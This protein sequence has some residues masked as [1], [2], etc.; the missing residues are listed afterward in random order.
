M[1]IYLHKRCRYRREDRP[2]YLRV[3]PYRPLQS[4]RGFARTTLRRKFTRKISAW[5]RWT[6][7]CGKPSRR[8]HA[9]SRWRRPC[10][11]TAAASTIRRASTAGAS[12]RTV[13]GT[14]AR[15]TLV[16]HHVNFD[17][18]AHFLNIFSK[19]ASIL[20]TQGSSKKTRRWHPINDKRTIAYAL[21]QRFW[22]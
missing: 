10:S 15:K 18:Q 1:R 16:L 11:S 19:E 21:N 22:C 3:D 6:R 12:E 8:R 17:F 9:S 14:F 4:T 5:G 7:R 13:L 2:K 20:V